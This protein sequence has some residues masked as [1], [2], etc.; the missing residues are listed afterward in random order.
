MSK[1]WYRRGACPLNLGLSGS[2]GDRKMEFLMIGV[3]GLI[4]VAALVI[5]AVSV[6]G[7]DGA[8]TGSE[9]LRR[10]HCDACGHEWE[11]SPKE[12]AAEVEGMEAL[13]CP[14]CGEKAGWAMTQCPKCKHWYV[15]EQT[16]LHR[17]HRRYEA[18]S[19][20]EEQYR[21]VCPKC[22]TD[23]NEYFHQQRRGD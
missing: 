16:K 14:N 18:P 6:F 9:G 23:R 3:L 15:S 21:E 20:E 1:P 7:G 10:Y 17:R 5:T 8:K 22:G 4:I 11:L 12:V 13:E 19:P 2:T